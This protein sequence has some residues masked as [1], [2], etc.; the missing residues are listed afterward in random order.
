MHRDTF[1]KKER[2]NTRKFLYIQY[3]TKDGTR[4]PALSN[5]SATLL[6]SSDFI[7]SGAVRSR[8][9]P[10]AVSNDEERHPHVRSDTHPKGD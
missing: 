10:H 9:K 4:T 3:D 6:G 8:Q 1:T 2:S 5:A 7:R